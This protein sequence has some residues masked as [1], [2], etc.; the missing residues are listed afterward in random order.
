MFLKIGVLKNFANL[1]EKYQ[2]FK[3]GTLLKETSTQL[4]SCEICE[5]FFKTLFFF[6]QN[7]FTVTA[8]VYSENL[9]KILVWNNLQIQAG[10]PSV[11]KKSQKMKLWVK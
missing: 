4:V 10:F 8:S 1:T 7:V 11:S 3:P 6:F 5:F 2:A 9:G